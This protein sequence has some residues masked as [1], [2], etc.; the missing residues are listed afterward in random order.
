MPRQ[1]R[2]EP[3]AVAHQERAVLTKALLRAAEKL[4]LRQKQLGVILGVSPANMSRVFSGSRM[5]PTD[6][7]EGER[8]LFF[9]R[10][11]RSLD[12][13]VGGE[14]E[15]ACAWFRAYNKHLEGVPADLVTTFRG[16][17][18]VAEYLDAMRGTY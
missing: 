10:I 1:R 9:L 13:L 17:N 6:G 15:K 11:Y 3:K 18:S 5:V 2:P 4:G 16:L 8:A 12:T 14:R 7:S